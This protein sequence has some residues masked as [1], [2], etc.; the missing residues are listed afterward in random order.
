MLYMKFLSTKLFDVIR[1]HNGIFL[2]TQLVPKNESLEFRTSERSTL[3]DHQNNA[4]TVG[5]SDPIP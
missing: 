4:E 5:F 1:L 3:K 2:K